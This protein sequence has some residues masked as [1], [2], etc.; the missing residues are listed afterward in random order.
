VAGSLSRSR[1]TP[2]KCTSPA[3]AIVK[4]LGAGA[5]LGDGFGAPADAVEDA[6]GEAGGVGLVGEFVGGTSDEHPI[7]AARAVTAP[8]M[9][10]RR[11]RRR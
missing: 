9:S 7:V 1:S 10:A 3:T 2:S 8:M 11:G 4:G 5:E 6:A